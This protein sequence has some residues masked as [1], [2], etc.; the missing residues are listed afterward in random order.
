MKPVL[1]V[2]FFDFYGLFKAVGDQ[3]FDIAM[4]KLKNACLS[5]RDYEIQRR[6][7]KA[8]DGMKQMLC[9]RWLIMI[10]NPEY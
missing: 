2:R 1:S 10:E 6:N 8:F 7:R 5:A 3:C 4:K 9:Q